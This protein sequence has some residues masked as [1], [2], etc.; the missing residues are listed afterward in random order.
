MDAKTRYKLIIEEVKRKVLRNGKPITNEEIADE[1]GFSR[2]HFQRLYTGSG[3]VRD[4]H[5]RDVI[6]HFPTVEENITSTESGE[7]HVPYIGKRRKQKAATGSHMV[8]FFQVRAQAGYVKAIDQQIYMDT[9]EKYAL[10][11]GISAQ[12]AVWAYWEIEGDSME[13]VFRSGDI[14]LTSQVHPMDWENL[15]NFYVYVIVTNE[16]VL[17][18][19]I[20]CKNA[21]EWVLISENEDQ[22]KQQIIQVEDIKEVWVYRK[23]FKTDASPT[24]EFKITV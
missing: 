16:R 13:P 1:L 7:P 5:I 10:P 11:P 12:G 14:I 8:P 20:Y 22:Y 24:K 15:K 19:R 17:I 2:E 3:V 21:K 6:L 4:K 18:K 9:L 23:T